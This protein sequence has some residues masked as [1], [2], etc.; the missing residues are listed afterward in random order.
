VRQELLS[1]SKDYF[2]K[3]YKTFQ[4]TADLY[5]CFMEKGFNLLKKDGLFS[6]IVAN[7][8]MR[9]NYAKNLR[10]WLSKKDIVEIID[11]G[12]LPVFQQATTY[13]CIFCIRKGEPSEKFS[14]VNVDDLNFNSLGEYV[15]SRKFDVDQERLSVEGW[16]LT[17][18]AEL[19]LLEKIKSKGVPLEQYVEGK[20]FRGVLTGFNA[21]FVIDEETKNRLIAEDPKSA[22]I[23]KPFLAGRDIKRYAPLETDKYL[24]FTRRGIDIKKYPAIEKYLLQFKENL[25]PKPEGWKGENW[26][27]RKP[28]KYKWYEI[29]DAVDYYEEFEK[30]K[31]IIPAISNIANNALDYGI[32]YSNDKT[33]IIV[34]SEPKFLLGIMNSKIIDYFV[35]SIASTKQGGYYEYKPM[36]VSKIPVYDE[37]NPN[38]DKIIQAVDSMLESQKQLQTAK[39]DS[40]RKILQ[41]KID[42][43][44]KQ[45]DRL[46]YKLYGL[47]ED[48]IKIVEG[49]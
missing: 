46:V 39:S 2:Q 19:D 44:D 38:R 17:N 13:P 35:Q 45:I 12:D 14:A 6:Y 43:I 10:E 20:I 22:E 3:H 40:D 34:H 1:E 15:Q 16:N 29:Q 5:V 23:I 24:I 21:A 42:A 33:S 27:G 28:G 7:K 37:I 25:M 9:A 48:E 30:E 47:T 11:F 4:G 18:T 41:Q 36:Y 49:E 8:W 32:H 31:I 26:P